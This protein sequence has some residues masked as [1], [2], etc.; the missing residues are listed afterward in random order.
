MYAMRMLLPYGGHNQARLLVNLFRRIHQ[1][2]DGEQ[3]RMLRSILLQSRTL[4]QIRRAQARDGTF[5][6][7][8]QFSLS[9]CS[10][11]AVE[12]PA[13]F[14]RERTRPT[15]AVATVQVVCFGSTKAA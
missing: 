6:P 10:P 14:R 13:L 9:A 12:D 11:A 15:V 5:S 3:I 7:P 2:D 1:M 4:H 8:P